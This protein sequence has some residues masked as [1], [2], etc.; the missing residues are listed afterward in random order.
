MKSFLSFDVGISLW[1]SPSKHR[2]RALVTVWH[3]KYCK[4]AYLGINGAL[5]LAIKEPPLLERQSATI[6]N[7]ISL[8]FVNRVI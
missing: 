4:G 8:K 3:C 5:Q 6:P 7:T 1:L 2:P